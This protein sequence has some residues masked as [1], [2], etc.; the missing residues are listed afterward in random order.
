KDLEQAV[1]AALSS[2][3]REAGSDLQVDIKRANGSVRWAFGSGVVLSPIEPDADGHEQMPEGFLWLARLTDAGWQVA[4]DGTAGYEELVPGAPAE[5]LSDE[6]KQLAGGIGVLGDNSMNLSAPWAPGQTWTYLGGPHGWTGSPRP[7]NSLDLT[8][9]DGH[10]LSAREGNVYK[11]CRNSAGAYTTWLRVKHPGG[12]W[13]D[14]YHLSNLQQYSDGKWLDRGAYLG[15]TGQTIDCGGSARSPHVH[16]SILKDGT[17]LEWNGRELGG[18]NIYQGGSAYQG[19]AERSGA[20]INAGS[21]T[22][23][24]IGVQYQAHVQNIGWQNWVANGGVAGTTGQGL[25]VEALKIALQKPAGTPSATGVCYQAHVQNIGWQAPVCNGGTAG[26]TGQGLRV[27]ALKVWLVNQPNRA[28]VCYRAHVQSI[29]WQG[30]VCDGG[31]A[32]TT[33]QGLRVE[34]LQV[35]ISP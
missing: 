14:Y 16:F 19:S 13:T 33:G 11:M 4:L 24:N 21:G 34:A 29:G 27:E 31:I 17:H 12:Y 22:M 35:R 7:W 5:V 8:G 32:G 6:E 23:Y 3:A 30:W 18:W 9:G 10:V 2:V 1:R 28:G 15:N 25:R 26:T 20:W